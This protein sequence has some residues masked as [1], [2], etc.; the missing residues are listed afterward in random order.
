MTVR[1]TKGITMPEAPLVRDAVEFAQS[2][3][4]NRKGSHLR[5]QV[6]E[7]VNLLKENVNLLKENVNLLKENVNLKE[8]NVNLKEEQLLNKLDHLFRGLPIQ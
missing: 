3:L 1:K 6:E 4:D 5:H 2:R 7:N 8:E